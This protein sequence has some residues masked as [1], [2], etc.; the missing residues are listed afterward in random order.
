MNI[1][2]SRR[3]LLKTLTSEFSGKYLINKKNPKGS[4][5]NLDLTPTTF[6]GSHVVPGALT[7][8]GL[9]AVESAYIPSFILTLVTLFVLGMYL[10]KI[11]KENALL[12]GLQTLVA[13]IITVA[14]ALLLGAI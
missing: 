4:N 3:I 12:Y 13:G 2:V 11:A 5:I 10:G 14:I 8:N 9:I 7:R 6:R 1:D